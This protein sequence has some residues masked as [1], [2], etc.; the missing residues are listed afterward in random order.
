MYITI[1]YMLN[2]VPENYRLYFSVGLLMAKNLAHTVKTFRFLCRSHCCICGQ[3]SHDGEKCPK[4]DLFDDEAQFHLSGCFNSQ[5]NKFPPL[6]REVPLHEITVGL[7]CAACATRIPASLLRPQIHADILLIFRRKLLKT[8]NHSMHCL[9]SVFGDR[10][11]VRGLYSHHSPGMKPCDL[12]LF[13]EHVKVK[14]IIL[15]VA[16]NT[17]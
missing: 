8:A 4:L 1:F 13:M 15:I 6:V 7:W 16:L 10:R 9:Q 3:Q 11:I 2:K 17:K 14:C 5:N 12:T